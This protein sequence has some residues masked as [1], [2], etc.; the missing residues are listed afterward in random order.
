LA[1]WLIEEGIGESR[2]LMVEGDKVLSAKLYWPGELFAGQHLS[3]RLTA[4]TKGSNRALAVTASGA[5]V[6]LDRVPNSISEGSSLNVVIT[7]APM[8]E[9]GR[10]K[11]AQGRIATASGKAADSPLSMLPAAR[12]VTHFPKGLWE[13]VWHSASEARITFVGGSLTFSVTP[14]MTLI[15]VDGEGTPQE[16]A[17]AAIDALVQG[18]RQFDLRGSIGVDFPTIADKAGRRA[19]DTAL[20]EALVDFPHE[21]TAM[22]GFGLVQIVA[23]ME[24]PSILHRFAHSRTA[25]AARY[26]LRQAEVVKGTG[27][28]LLSVHPALKAKMKDEWLQELKRRTGREVRIATDP[29]LALEAGFAQAVPL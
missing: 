1:E 27:A 26:V 11:R 25:A 2:A 29:A 5:E 15:D 19:V 3:A 4:R 28:L 17:L 7:R 21:R 18:I 14:A 20:E 23:R 10:L 16:L 8:A 6:L 13:D 22:N 12:V 24:G 9:R